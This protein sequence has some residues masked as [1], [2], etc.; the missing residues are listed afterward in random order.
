LINETVVKCVIV[1]HVAIDFVIY[2]P[3]YGVKNRNYLKWQKIQL[4][5]TLKFVAILL[6]IYVNNS[7]I[8]S[9]KTKTAPTSLFMM[10]YYVS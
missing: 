5:K 2:G 1:K 7:I 8:E 6:I 9:L 4:K 3:G 10:F